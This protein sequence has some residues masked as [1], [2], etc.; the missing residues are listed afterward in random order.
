MAELWDARHQDGSLAGFDLTRGQAIPDGYYHLV[1]EVIIRHHDGSHLLMQRDWT[2]LDFPG[3]FE[4]GASGSALK[5]EDAEMAARREVREETGITAGQF[6]QLYQV[7]QGPAIFVGFLC[8]TD[9]PKD[10]IQFQVG[11]TIDYRWLD[12]ADFQDYFI[13][14]PGIIY[15]RDRMQG[16]F[17]N[18][19]QLSS[20]RATH[21]E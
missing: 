12:D 7:V 14:R 8:L 13:H 1:C 19:Y 17:D 20:K 2:K 21:D 4:I 10:Q 16:Y 6:S 15:Q 9:W 5:G 3:E 11:E 18:Y